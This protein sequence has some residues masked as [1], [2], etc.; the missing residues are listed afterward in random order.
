MATHAEIEVDE[1][2]IEDDI[3]NEYAGRMLRKM[4]QNTDLREIKLV[5]GVDKQR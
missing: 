5:A 3:D 2:D 4:F 1:S